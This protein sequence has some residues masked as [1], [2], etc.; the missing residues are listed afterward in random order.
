[1]NGSDITDIYSSIKVPTPLSKSSMFFCKDPFPVKRQC[2]IKKK[3]SALGIRK[4]KF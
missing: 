2:C 3:R 4:Y 1:M